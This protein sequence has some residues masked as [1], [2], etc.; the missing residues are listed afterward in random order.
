M[1]DYA[2]TVKYWDKVFA[3]EAPPLDVDSPLPFPEIEEG[4]RWACRGSKTV[5]DFGC[6]NGRVLFRC[7][8]LGV[9]KGLGL[10]I[11]TNAVSLA[12]K[13]AEINGLAPRASF[14]T[15]SISRLKD[16]SD[17]SFDAIILFNVIDNIIPDDAR[18]LIEEVT[19]ITRPDGKI[20]LKLNDYLPDAS[21]VN[22]DD[23][24]VIRTGFYREA[25]GLFLWNLRCEDV[26]ELLKPKLE[27]RWSIRVEFQHLD[28]WNRLYCLTKAS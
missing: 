14:S 1:H 5:L 7:L 8:A 12:Q 3:Q 9:E 22:N 25:A 16:F 2:A 15:G 4:L 27:I 28:M 17:R 10:D 21:L 23:Y 11:S 18:D 6:G 20:L 19:R 13:T 26:S 24:S